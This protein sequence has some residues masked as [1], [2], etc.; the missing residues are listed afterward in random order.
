MTGPAVADGQFRDGTPAGAS[1][2]EASP[3]TVSADGAELT[4]AGGVASY[5][6]RRRSDDERETDSVLNRY[7]KVRHVVTCFHFP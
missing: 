3:V 1:H 4:A 7:L 6:R 2:R 5:S